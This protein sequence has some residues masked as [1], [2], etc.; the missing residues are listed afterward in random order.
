MALLGGWFAPVWFTEEMA[1][2]VAKRLLAGA[3]DI[4]AAVSQTPLPLPL[5]LTTIN[6]PNIVTPKEKDNDRVLSFYL[7]IPLGIDFTK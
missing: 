6:Q 2:E 7:N 4:A 1:L 5:D 3:P